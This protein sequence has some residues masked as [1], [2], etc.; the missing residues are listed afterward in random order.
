ME[1]KKILCYVIFP[2]LSIR[3]T[4]RA[5]NWITFFEFPLDFAFRTKYYCQNRLETTQV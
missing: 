3:L 2:I 5:Q 1:Q 4:K